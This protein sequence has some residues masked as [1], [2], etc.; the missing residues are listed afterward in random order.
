MELTKTMRNLFLR[1][2]CNQNFEI[3]MTSS[4]SLLRTQTNLG[5][6]TITSEGQA[7]KIYELCQTLVV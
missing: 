3:Y 2:V 7:Q 6:F 1:R 5:T 4:Y